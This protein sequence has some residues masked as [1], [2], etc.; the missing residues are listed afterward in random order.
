MFAKWHCS[1]LFWV[2]WTEKKWTQMAVSQHE[3]VPCLKVK[4]FAAIARHSEKRRHLLHRLEGCDFTGGF[5][6]STW[7]FWL[8]LC[9]SFARLLYGIY[10]VLSRL[11]SPQ[12]VNLTAFL[13]QF[14]I[15]REFHSRTMLDNFVQ[16][17]RFCYYGHKCFL[18]NQ[19]P[20][21]RKIRFL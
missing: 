16:L 10:A 18:T 15:L 4:S 7:E 11:S 20:F 5:A 9:F 13:K 3:I 19:F 17:Y 1:D 21:P 2:C 12:I 14:S 6:R 8:R